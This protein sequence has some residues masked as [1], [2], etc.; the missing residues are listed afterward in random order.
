MV[1]I[2]ELGLL[3]IGA[4]WFI[5]AFDI[6]GKKEAKLNKQ[7]VLLYTLGLAL[8]LVDGIMNGSSITNLLNVLTIAGSM[9]VLFKMK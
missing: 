8:L 6:N 1:G 2:T 9:I 7:F 4:S 3:F 5:Q